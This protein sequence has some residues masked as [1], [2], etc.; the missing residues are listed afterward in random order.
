MDPNNVSN[1]EDS[2]LIGDNDESLSC[3]NKLESSNE[4]SISQTNVVNS[5]NDNL[6]DYSNND[7]LLTSDNLGAVG[8]N[9]LSHTSSSANSVISECSTDNFLS[10]DSSFKSN[11]ITATPAST[12]LSVDDTHYVNSQTYFKVALKD[13][14]GNLLGNQRIFLEVNNQVFSGYTDI[15]GIANIKTTELA[16]GSYLVNVFYNGNSQY[17]A[18]SLSKKVKVLSSIIGSD[19]IKYCGDTSKYK[20]T[21]WNGTSL[22]ANAEVTFK[23][24]GKTYTGTTNDEGVASIKI[25]LVV[26]EYKVMV[27]NP[28][29]AQKISNKVVIKKDKTTL[30]VNSKN[31]IISNHKGSFT[32]T[33]KT[34]HNSLLKNK[35]I[36]FTYNGKTVTSKTNAKGK[37]T[38]VIPVLAKGTYK[39]TFKYGGSKNYKS[40]SG[41]AYLLVVNPKTKVTSSK[42]IMT[43]GDGSKFKVKLT[44]EKGKV[45]SNKNIKLKIKSNI[46][47]SKTDS[48]GIAKFSL[49]DVKPGVYDA[50]YYYSTRS[51]RDYS[52]G[53]EKVII[54]KAPVKITSDNLVINS[55]NASSYEV[56]ITDKSGKVLKGVSVKSKINGKSYIYKTNSNGIAKLKITKKAGYY[57]IKTLVADSYYKSGTI[58]K[59]ITVKGAKFVAK[60]KYA[61]SG[62]N[63]FYSVKLV[64]EKN[65]PI[66]DKEIVFIF[67]GNNLTSK[68]NSKGI[69][70]VNL[71]EL[72]KGTHNIQFKYKSIHG[73]SKIFVVNKVTIKEIISASKYVKKYISKHS[74]LPSTVK[75]GDVSFKTADYLYLASKAI[76]ILKSSNKKD[77]SIK[78]LKNPTKPKAANDLGYL[79]DYLSV[80]KKVV[81]TAESKGIL[82]NSVNSK[83]GNIGYKGIVYAFSKII[84]SYSKNKKMPSYIAIKALKSSSYSFNGGLNS[85]NKIKNLFAYLSASKNCEVNNAKIKKLVS[86]LTKGCKNDKQKANAIFKYVR[87]TIS[88]KFY[89]N[90]KFGA[91][92]ILNTKAGN[93]V[94]HAHLLVAM[95]RTAGLA[96]RYVHAKCTFSNGRTYGHVW[97]QVLIG[98]TWTCADA[99]SSRNSLGKV[100]NWNT[101]TYKLQGFYSS[102]PF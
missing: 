26:G 7:N 88:Y 80:A 4:V 96:S 27:F 102:L 22:L 101:H 6:K 76:V 14:N 84:T 77:I 78:I 86:K 34:K 5:H 63:I 100:A 45:L 53:A 85:K 61:S 71:N 82:P 28:Y 52:S 44:N 95:Y 15:N 49:K 62:D 13:T 72:S 79:R 25:N 10:A 20:A 42:V 37:A 1:I 89:F 99:T 67:E 64:N 56:K 91:M 58:S 48:K 17:S 30:A 39:I 55:D 66:K 50:K 33:L 68:T 12:L 31:Y 94:D 21:F 18:S 81:K 3:Q 43:Y 9:N 29:S 97:S 23:I 19:L 60:N 8:E 90:T 24:N 57:S 11:I 54:F 41:K 92:G 75:I 2:N 51:A 38:I 47:N 32:V 36:S 59:H 93:C 87:D 74:K 16:V 98:N 65:K 83:V 70:K 35:K 73:L 40:S 69:A 46:L